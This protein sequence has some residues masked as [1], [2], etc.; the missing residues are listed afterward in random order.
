MNSRVRQNYDIKSE[1]GANWVNQFLHASYTY[2]SLEPDEW[3]NGASALR[4]EKA[5]LDEH[6]ITS[7]HMDPH[8]Y[9]FLEIHYLDEEVK[10]IKKLGDYLTNLKQVRASEDSLDEFGLLSGRTEFDSPLLH[11]HLLM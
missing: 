3:G 1:A 5:L 4:L 9:D 6:T 7:R 2:L 10:L 8:M 11:S